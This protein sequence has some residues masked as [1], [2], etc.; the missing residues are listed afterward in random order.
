MTSMSY[1]PLSSVAQSNLHRLLAHRET[2]V[3]AAV[4]LDKAGC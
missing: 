1:V 3:E 2:R 4:A